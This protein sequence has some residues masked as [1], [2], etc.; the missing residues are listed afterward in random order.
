MISI[1][2]DQFLNCDEKLMTIFISI[3]N[4][5]NFNHDRFFFRCIC[6]AGYTGKNCESKYIPCSPSPCQNGGTCK[7]TSHYSYEC[8]C[9]PGKII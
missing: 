6:E 4:N 7:Q 8:K 9:P 2:F 1:L 5:I 3:L